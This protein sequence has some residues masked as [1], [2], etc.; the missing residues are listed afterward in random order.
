MM[1][2][3]MM[4]MM[5]AKSSDLVTIWNFFGENLTYMYAMYFRFPI[6]S[7]IVPLRLLPSRNLMMVMMMM[8]MIIIIILVLSMI[9]ITTG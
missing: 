3:M 5:I 1:M 4:M 7:G 9:I 8:M 2:M 6:V